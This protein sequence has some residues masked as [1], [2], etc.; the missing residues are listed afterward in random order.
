M[1]VNTLIIPKE[2][3]QAKLEQ[4]R[5]IVGKRRLKEDDKLE[6]LYTRISKGARVVNITAA[7]RQTGL[8]ELKQPR[9]AIARADWPDVFCRRWN[10]PGPNWGIEFLDH[11]GWAHRV[12]YTRP[13]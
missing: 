5:N 7:F 6:T 10:M 11:E 1:N 9:L 13:A 4:Y 8:N 3:A 2:E 12:R